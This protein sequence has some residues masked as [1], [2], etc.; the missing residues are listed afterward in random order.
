MEVHS[1]AVETSGCCICARTLGDPS[2]T[3]ENIE[4]SKLE[5]T[6]QAVCAMDSRAEEVGLAK[7]FGGQ[8]IMTT[9]KMINTEL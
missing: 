4:D 7:P 9:S 5:L 8:K 1:V 6:R 3:V 2:R